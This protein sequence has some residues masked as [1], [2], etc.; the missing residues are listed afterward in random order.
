MYTYFVLQGGAEHG[1]PILV[2]DLQSGKPAHSCGLL[3]IGDAILSVNGH[4]LRNSNHKDAVTVLQSVGEEV[5][6]EVAYIA[7]LVSDN[8]D[9][10]GEQQHQH[11]RQ[12][13]LLSRDSSVPSQNEV[14]SLNSASSESE[15]DSP[16]SSVEPDH[17]TSVPSA[18]LP[19]LNSS[20]PVSS[21]SVPVSSASVLC[22]PR[23][24]ATQQHKLM[25]SF[26]APHNGLEPNRQLAHPDDH[27]DENS[28]FN[29]SVAANGGVAQYTNYANFYTDSP[30]A[31]VVSAIELGPN[32]MPK[33][34]NKPAR[35]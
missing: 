8:S 3:R 32:D 17:V 12:Q 20:L 5:V 13:P 30:Y 1:V 2:S 24:A 11:Q 29:N 25:A 23:K 9:E 4:N 15:Y 34:K 6:M 35:V 19:T 14:D 7:D 10:E 27:S 21:S 28:N 33:G 22:K 16:D 26:G 31:T 18:S